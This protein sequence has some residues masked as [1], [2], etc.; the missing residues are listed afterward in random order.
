MPFS[1]GCAERSR[2]RCIQSLE[3]LG[4]EGDRKR[5]SIFLDVGWSAGF[6]NCDDAAAANCPSQCNRGGRAPVSSPDLRQR[7]V[8]YYEVIVS[9]ER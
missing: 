7:A 5:R 1:L 3:V 2:K 8:T 4:R 6:G 9:A